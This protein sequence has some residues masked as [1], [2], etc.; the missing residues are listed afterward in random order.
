MIMFCGRVAP[1]CA[2][3]ELVDAQ[4]W[5]QALVYI[6]M[7]W[8]YMIKSRDYNWYYIGMSTN[9]TRRL[10]EHNAGSV[11]STKAYRPFILVYKK[12]FENT[13]DARDSEKFLKISSN[14]EKL[15]R[16]LSI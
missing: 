3:R 7:I 4:R 10:N 12:N 13:S 15:I 11:K 8:V 9:I 1:A 16:S 14:K 5:L 6:N 2:G